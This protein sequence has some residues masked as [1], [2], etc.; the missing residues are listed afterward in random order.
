[1]FAYELNFKSVNVSIRFLQ[2]F[3]RPVCLNTWEVKKPD[4]TQHFH[5]V[6]GIIWIW[7]TEVLV[8]EFRW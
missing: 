7:E 1:M 6:S 4:W 3:V 5:V 8:S 2:I